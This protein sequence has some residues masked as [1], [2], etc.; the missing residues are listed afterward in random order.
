LFQLF[1]GEDELFRHF[2]VSLFDH[3]A[4]LDFFQL[5]LQ[6]GEHVFEGGSGGF[7]GCA[8]LGI[9]AIWRRFCF[10]AN[11]VELFGQVLD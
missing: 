3:C 7:F 10:L 5:L 4:V 1:C 11:L 9:T 2:V 6:Q 8:V